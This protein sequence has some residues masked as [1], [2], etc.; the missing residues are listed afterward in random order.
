MLITK[1]YNN[2]CLINIKTKRLTAPDILNYETKFKLVLKLKNILI[3]TLKYQ[4]CV[5]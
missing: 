4:Y 5:K 1:V 2:K 3:A